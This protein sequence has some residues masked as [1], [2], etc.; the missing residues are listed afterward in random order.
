MK[1]ILSLF[2]IVITASLVGCNDKCDEGNQATPASFFVEI[3]S[4]RTY[5]DTPPIQEV[6][7]W[8]APTY[9]RVGH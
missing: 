3:I 8:G 4:S 1:N 2:L 5:Y 7:G 6:L 9:A